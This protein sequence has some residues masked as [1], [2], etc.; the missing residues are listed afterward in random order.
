MAVLDVPSVV[1]CCCLFGVDLVVLLYVVL[2]VLAVRCCAL[3]VIS[4]V[5]AVRCCT[6]ICFSCSGY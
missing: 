4:V 6:V 1:F 2:V 3:F 5:V